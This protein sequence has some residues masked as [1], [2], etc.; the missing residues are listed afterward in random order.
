[1]TR[2]RGRPG[3]GAASNPNWRSNIDASAE[4]NSSSPSIRAPSGATAPTMRVPRALPSILRLRSAKPPESGAACAS[5]FTRAGDKAV[6]RS[7][8]RSATRPGAIRRKSA[9]SSPRRWASSASS[10][11]APDESACPLACKLAPPTFWIDKRSSCKRSPCRSTLALMRPEST[12]PSPMRA[13]RTAR[14]SNTKLRSTPAA[15][16]AGPVRS[17]RPSISSADE[18]RSANRRARSAPKA[19]VKAAAPVKVERSALTTSS[20][21]AIAACDNSTL[22]SIS[23]ARNGMARKRSAR[24][25]ST[26]PTQ[27]ARR[28][29]SRALADRAPENC[30]ASPDSILPSSDRC[31]RPGRFAFT[32]SALP[33]SA[34]PLREPKRRRTSPSVSP[35]IWSAGVAN[36][37]SNGQSPAV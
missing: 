28:G 17:G 29:K 4:V 34:S 7:E 27:S 5:N 35:P 37:S 2:A 6:A 31:E 32:A 23:M 9:A 18:V 21:A 8:I 12:M 19:R 10:I 25:P 14:A 33:V 3:T 1:M 26:R 24:S 13:T 15:A 36:S 22:P 11:R 16:R 30:A 20:R